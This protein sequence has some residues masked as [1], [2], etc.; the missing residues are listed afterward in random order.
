MSKL[1]PLV[2][3]G[4]LTRAPI[5]LHDLCLSV[6]LSVTREHLAARFHLVEAC[7]PRRA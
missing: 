2:L 1:V 6:D 4:H 7:D 5:D 3:S